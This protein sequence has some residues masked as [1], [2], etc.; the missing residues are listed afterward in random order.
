MASVFDHGWFELTVAIIILVCIF[1]I[2]IVAF[3]FHRFCK[4]RIGRVFRRGGRPPCPTCQLIDMGEAACYSGN[5]PDCGEVPASLRENQ[6][7][8]DVGIDR[9]FHN[10]TERDHCR[11]V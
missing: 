6:W 2:L 8:I 5:C 9:L 10:V 11:L 4:D 7:N 3:I 1:V